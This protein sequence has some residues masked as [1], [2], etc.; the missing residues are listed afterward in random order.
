MSYVYNLIYKIWN[1]II[2][3]GKKELLNNSKEI[4]GFYQRGLN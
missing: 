4:V 1:K 2:R 3:K